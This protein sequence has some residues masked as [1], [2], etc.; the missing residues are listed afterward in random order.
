MTSV[1][2]SVLDLFG[3]GI[4]KIVGFK[5]FRNYVHLGTMDASLRVDMDR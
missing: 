4:A 2:I 3:E 5:G 1:D